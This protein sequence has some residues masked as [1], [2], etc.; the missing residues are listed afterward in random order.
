MKKLLLKLYDCIGMLDDINDVLESA[1][2]D[3]T[4]LL[5]GVDIIVDF[6]SKENSKFLKE[7]Q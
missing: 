4:Q 1:G 7:V 5:E 6:Y 2:V 3:T